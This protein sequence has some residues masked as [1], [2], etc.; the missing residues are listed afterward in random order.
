MCFSLIERATYDNAKNKWIPEV[1][2]H[3]PMTPIILVGTQKDLR[4][5]RKQNHD[6]GVISTGEVMYIVV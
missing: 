4:D 5:E 3:R 2:H 6:Q 1:R